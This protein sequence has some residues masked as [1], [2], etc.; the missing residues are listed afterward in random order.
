MPIFKESENIRVM[1]RYLPVIRFFFRGVGTLPSQRWNS[2][3]TFMIVEGATLVTSDIFLR[4][5]L[6]VRLPEIPSFGNMHTHLITYISL[7]W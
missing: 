7:L 1:S 3:F 6:T 2:L 4:V 5:V